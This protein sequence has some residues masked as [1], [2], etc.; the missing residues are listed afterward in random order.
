MRPASASGVQVDIYM[1]YSKLPKFSQTPVPPPE[2]PPTT[3]ATGFCTRCGASFAPRTR[4]CG[5]CGA[6]TDG[7]ILYAA[8]QSSEQVGLIEGWLSI[9]VGVVLLLMSPNLIRYLLSPAA[10]EKN[11]P[12]TDATGQPLA[13]TKSVFFW[14][15]L[16]ITLFAI[17]LIMEGL[18]LAFARKALPVA[19]AFGVTVFAVAI[20]AG[21][22]IWMVTQ[23]YGFQ[24]ISGLA[25]VFGIYIAMQQWMLLQSL[26][27]A[28]TS[29]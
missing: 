12:I 23:G 17:V 7:G 26:R 25:T 3:V 29:A 20:N 27:S 13:Y 6:P 15:D 10:F 22:V 4:F 16:S 18:V 24:I 1:D 21:Y 14:G 19:L 8:P 28:Q 2:P 5:S 9:G 11:N